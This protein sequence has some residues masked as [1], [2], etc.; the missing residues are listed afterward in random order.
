MSSSISPLVVP[1]EVVLEVVPLVEPDVVLPLV[2]LVLWAKASF[3][4]PNPKKVTAAIAVPK[5]IVLSLKSPVLSLLIVFM[6]IILK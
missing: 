3:S 2:V 1:P 5:A 6:V 4:A